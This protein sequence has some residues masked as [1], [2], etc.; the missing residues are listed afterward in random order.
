MYSTTLIKMYLKISSFG[1]ALFAL[2]SS[3]ISSSETNIMYSE[4]ANF[5]IFLPQGAFLCFYIVLIFNG[6]GDKKWKKMRKKSIQ[7]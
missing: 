1:Y 7:I 6:P 2:F 5:E 3:V 4:L